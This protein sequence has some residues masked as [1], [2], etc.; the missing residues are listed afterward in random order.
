MNLGVAIIGIL[1][2][3]VCALPFVLTTRSRK[4]K[5]KQL[6]MLVK[7]LANQHQSEI[8]QSESCGYYAIGIDES[9]KAVSFVSKIEDVVK[10]QFVDLTTIK[11]CE[12]SNIRRTTANND[13][14]IDRL[15][16]IL[17]PVDTNKSDM[18]LEFYNAEVSFQLSGELQSIEK[19][20]ILINN[21]L[22]SKK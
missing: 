17:S 12:L 19:W 9:K 22:N 14:I 1:G 13:K 11:K 7:N 2:V 6:L 4:K 18:V 20:H 10:Q 8:T 15:N 3:A 21:L 5:E 16:L